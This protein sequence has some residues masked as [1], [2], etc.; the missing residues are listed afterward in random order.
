MAK[1][2]DAKVQWNER[3]SVLPWD[4]LQSEVIKAVA[5]NEI[6]AWRPVQTMDEVVDD[7]DAERQ[8]VG[9]GP[10]ETAESLLAPTE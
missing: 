9:A 5:S 1:L 6:P 4:G 10:G 3:D 7:D 2:V 8:D